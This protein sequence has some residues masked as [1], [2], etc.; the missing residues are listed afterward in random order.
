V[1]LPTI[2]AARRAFSFKLSVTDGDVA[3]EM[4]ND[5]PES[6]RR[7]RLVC[8]ISVSSPRGGYVPVL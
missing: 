7:D 2:S 6:I 1:E 8:W 5:H 4:A 3:V